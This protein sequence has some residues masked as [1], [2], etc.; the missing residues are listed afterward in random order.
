MLDDIIEFTQGLYLVRSSSFSQALWCLMK[1]W[2]LAKSFDAWWYH[3]FYP[4]ALLDEIIECSQELWCWMISLILSKGFA[5]WDHRVQPRAL[6]LDDIIDFIQ[7][8]LLD[9]II[10]C[11]QEL[12]CWM[13][14]SSIWI[15]SWDH[16]INLVM[17]PW[18]P[19]TGCTVG[20]VQVPSSDWRWHVPRC[21]NVGAW[22]KTCAE[23]PSTLHGPCISLG[24]NRHTEWENRGGLIYVLRI[25][26]HIFHV[27][28]KCFPDFV[29]ADV[30]CPDVP[31]FF[32]V[33]W[34][35]QGFLPVLQCA[36]RVFDDDI[37]E[38]LVVL[39]LSSRYH[40]IFFCDFG[41]TPGLWASFVC[42]LYFQILLIQ[43]RQQIG[44]VWLSEFS[45]MA[46]RQR[47][48]HHQC[49]TCMRHR[50][51]HT[52][53]G[54]AFSCACCSTKALPH[55]S[56]TSILRSFSILED[57]GRFKRL[58]CTRRNYGDGWDGSE[59]ILPSETWGHE[60]QRFWKLHPSKAS[61]QR[62]HRPWVARYFSDFATRPSQ[63]FQCF[64]WIDLTLTHCATK[65]RRKPPRF[66]CQYPKR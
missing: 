23:N 58:V 18:H 55:T 56:K 60:E 2:S 24:A 8:L 64:H 22:G 63:R 42:S 32:V 57:A 43:T 21:A 65:T 12:W 7:G 28:L 33:S 14:S 5:W 4:R 52:C 34:Y 40:P 30:A 61:H 51:P 11:S 9:E 10:E 62:N 41:I 31:I 45:C 13:I 16:G 38:V 39:F 26:K 20:R 35:H 17:R 47:S 25:R 36:M 50:A 15:L 44:E 48:Q 53:P 27:L 37:F 46:F 1:S 54:G 19:P 59:Q 29:C 3:W 66:A 6:M 49:G